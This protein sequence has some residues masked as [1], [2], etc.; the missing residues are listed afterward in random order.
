MYSALAVKLKLEL[1]EMFLQLH[2]SRLCTSEHKPISK[3]SSG[4]TDLGTVAETF[5]F[6]FAAL[7]IFMGTVASIMK[8]F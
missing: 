3:G 2:W 7:D 8:K 1:L 6:F 4:G 5:F